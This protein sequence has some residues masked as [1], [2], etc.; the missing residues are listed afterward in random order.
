MY[1]FKNAPLQRSVLDPGMRVRYVDGLVLGA[2]E[3][4]QEQLY[5]IERDR[6]HQRWLHGFGTMSG[7]R[8]WLG[9]D[10]EKVHVSS[11]IAVDKKGQT[12]TV[13]EEQCAP[14][15]EWIEAHPEAGPGEQFSLFIYLSHSEYETA[16]VPLPADPCKPEDD[17]AAPS[18]IADS[19]NL[20]F[21]YSRLSDKEDIPLYKLK[22]L[23]NR[24]AVVEGE[25][26]FAPVE[27]L[28]A[29]VRKLIDPESEYNALAED[30]DAI[31]AE[32][33]AEI[34]VVSEDAKRIVQT[35]TRIWTTEFHP[36]V[37]QLGANARTAAHHDPSILLAE[38]QIQTSSS[39]V[40]ESTKLLLQDER[41]IL[42][43]DQIYHELNSTDT[44]GR[45]AQLLP[46]SKSSRRR[47][48]GTATASLPP[49]AE[50]IEASE[51]GDTMSKLG[52]FELNKIEPDNY[53]FTLKAGNSEV[54]LESNSY[55][56]ESGARKAVSAVR[57]YALHD[58]LFERKKDRAGNDFFVLNRSS[59]RMLGRSE[60]YNSRQAMEKGIRSVKRHAP[61]AELKDLTG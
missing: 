8:V 30:D 46:S 59:G 51:P 48:A 37:K 55:K 24:V 10:L 22:A 41:P 58:H 14:L 42:L 4:T 44:L 60:I 32:S 1:N 50:D 33:E 36:A 12:I 38:I 28:E 20:R 17:I 18:R 47:P 19:F 53:T 2:D 9:A 16:F 11:G 26:P 34:K 54:I 13:P 7:L 52:I 5:F 6:T 35:A 40:A 57:E 39:N 15:Q 25:D 31:K 21:E 27:G 45:I 3:F 23:L 56:T 61:Y 49:D 29:W 43:G